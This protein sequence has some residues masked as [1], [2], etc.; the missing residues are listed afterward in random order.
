MARKSR[1]DF[2][3]ALPARHSMAGSWRTLDCLWKGRPSGAFDTESGLPAPDGLE[4][5]FAGRSTASNLPDRKATCSGSP[6]SDLPSGAAATRKPRLLFRF[7][8]VF[9]FR[10]ADRQ[11]LA[12]FLQLP[13]RFTRFEPVI[14]HR[15]RCNSAVRNCQLD[16]PAALAN[17]M[18]AVARC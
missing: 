6:S 9:L 1:S 7:D 16:T 3:A 10:I 11:F 8:G 5:S 18:S 14:A 15:K 12:E 4:L 13:P 17:A 2:L